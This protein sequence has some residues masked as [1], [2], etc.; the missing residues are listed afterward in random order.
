[1]KKN[2]DRSPLYAGIIRAQ[3]VR[4][5][6]SIEDKIFK[7]ADKERHQ[8]FL[9]PEGKRTCEYYP[10]GL[11]TSLPLD[12]QEEMLHS[13][14]GLENVRMM[15]PGYGIE[16]DVIDARELLPTLECKKVKNL[17]FAGQVNGTTGYEEAASQGL[18]AGI[19]AAAAI[20]D[21]KPLVLSRSESYIGVL[22][23]DL[24]TKG[25]NEPYRMFTSRAEY[26]LLL[27]E[28]NADLRL[29][30]YGRSYGLF[31]GD[32]WKRVEELRK[33]ISVLRG[34]LSERKIVPD[35]Q[36]N[37]KLKRMGTERIKKKMSLAD[38]LRRPEVT[39]AGL[40]KAF[41]LSSF[42]SRARENVEYEFRYEAFIRR[43]AEEARR[44]GEIEAVRIPEDFSYRNLA[45]LSNE[46]KEKLEKIRPRTLA[47]ASRIS[48]VTPAALSA[49]LVYLSR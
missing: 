12:V 10:N 3:G 34:L 22:I 33:E 9:E 45:G 7:F 25:T 37:R 43:E 41:S 27:R 6:P 23:D 32:E 4:Y 2:L 21:L 44:L 31:P 38:L 5:C 42:S 36:T 20:L 46:V 11:S 40:E 30:S 29:S 48:G 19:N 1:I 49:L 24:V 16:H 28:Q 8:I 13:I 17:F 14:P 47:Q 15:R 35:E 26:R 18:V 39:F